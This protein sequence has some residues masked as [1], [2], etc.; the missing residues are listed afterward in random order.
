[1]VPPD[2]RLSD[3]SGSRSHR[4][5]LL[6]ALAMDDRVDQ[7]LTKG[8][9][10]DL[11]VKAMNI[12][13]I[14]RVRF[15]KLEGINLYRMETALCSF[16]KLFRTTKGRYLGYYLDRQSE[17]IQQ[18]SNDGWTGVNWNVLW[19]ARKESLDP[20][21]SGKTT[22]QENRFPLFLKNGNVDQLDWMFDDE[23][24]TQKLSVREWF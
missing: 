13:H 5:G 9:V 8:E 15:P 2:L 24:K 19:Q 1:M 18:V 10:A 12:L 7:P 22:V 4:N 23:K 17:E 20:R 16:K 6:Y 11:E 3:F 14:M 21:L